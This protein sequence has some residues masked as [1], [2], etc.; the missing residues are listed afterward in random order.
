MGKKQKITVKGPLEY[1]EA[2]EYLENIAATLRSGRMTLQKGVESVMLTPPPFVDFSIE[3]SQKDDKSKLSIKIGWDGE[4]AGFG[5]GDVVNISSEGPAPS[6]IT[7]D[8]HKV[9]FG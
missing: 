3:A 1:Q 6:V 7:T 4:N 5:L 2:A 8:G 9:R